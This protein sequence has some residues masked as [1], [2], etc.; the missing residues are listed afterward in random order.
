MC[1]Q[2]WS[3]I[4]FR[5]VS[6]LVCNIKLYRGFVDIKALWQIEIHSR[7]ANNIIYT[8]PNVVRNLFLLVIFC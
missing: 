6:F 1:T 4:I 7:K 2:I 5:F 8:I 3:K